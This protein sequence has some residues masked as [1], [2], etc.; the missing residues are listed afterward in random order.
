MLCICIIHRK[1]P[2]IWLCTSF[3]GQNSVCIMW[4]SMT[5]TGN[6]HRN[7]QLSS[8]VSSPKREIYRP[9]TKSPRKK[10]MKCRD[11]KSP[12]ISECFISDINNVDNFDWKLTN[13]NG[14][15][16]PNLI[17]SSFI[18]YYFVHVLHML[19]KNIQSAC[20]CLICTVHVWVSL[21]HNIYWNTL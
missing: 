9:F 5:L 14:T 16:F 18:S 10:W 13:L 19:L 15:Y 2:L 20:F 3:T 21:L 11:S 12:C 4:T 1:Y 6:E 7:N 17:K 8:C